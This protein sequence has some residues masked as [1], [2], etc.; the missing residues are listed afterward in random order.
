ML[1]RADFMRALEDVKPAF[2]ISEEELSGAAPYGVIDYSPHIQSI[3]STGL[4]FVQAVRTSEKSP[5]F[6]V[7]VHGPHGAG[8]TALAAEIGLKSEFPFV[9][10][11]RPIDVGTNEGAKLEY[12]RRAFSDA[13]KSALSI[14]ILDSV[15]KIIDW[16]PI[17][18][19]FS[20]AVVQ[21]LGA[22]LETRPPKVYPILAKLLSPS[23]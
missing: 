10:L 7:L 12:L 22:V 13:Y 21:Y 9:K 11:I 6:S 17:G 2:G 15:E 18:P 3:L 14:V 8:K 19:R 16:N 4:S 5:L 23:N 1:T 20:N